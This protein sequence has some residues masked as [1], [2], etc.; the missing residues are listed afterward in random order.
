[1]YF[2]TAILIVMPNL[3]DNISDSANSTIIVKSEFSVFFLSLFLANNYSVAS[4]ALVPPPTISLNNSITTSRLQTGGIAV[5]NC[6][7]AINSSYLDIPVH[8]VFT[9]ILRDSVIKS[10]NCF[11][12]SES[13]VSDTNSYFF[14]STLKIAPIIREADEGVLTC[15]V[16]ITPKGSNKHISDSLTIKKSIILQIGGIIVMCVHSLYI[17]LHL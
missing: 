17:K 11:K 8:A 4:I 16:Y 10:K 15:R 2:C 14:T 3:L 7:S 1:M 13:N 12:I 6:N 5:Y 9:W